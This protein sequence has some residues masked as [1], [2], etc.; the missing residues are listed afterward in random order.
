MRFPSRIEAHYRK[1]EWTENGIGRSGARVLVS[2]DSVLKI[3][4]ASARTER[5]VILLRWLEGRLPAP[6]V[7]A[8]E[9]SDGYSY[10]L[11]TRI[12]GKMACDEMYLDQPK[13]LLSRLAEAIQMTWAVDIAD[14]PVMRTPEM[15]LREARKRVEDGLVDRDD[16]DP[17]T[18][19]PN[20][21]RDPEALLE[22]LE[23]HVPP[24]DPVFSHGDFCLPNV[25]LNE[26]GVSG[27][28]DLGDAGVSD[29]WRDLALCHRSLRHNVDGTYG[30]VRPGH[31]ADGL[32]DLLGVPKDPEKLK[33]YLLLDE[34]S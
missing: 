16:A 29:R 30:K 12:T 3:Q 33:W 14:C 27:L 2:D 7:I 17:G 1:R 22:W 8:C 24:M 23:G 9:Q 18:Y 4:P 6:R 28:I 32:F 15:M 5:E 13:L 19:G 20:G 34:L 25:L 11:M 10:L 26:R 31:D 21:F